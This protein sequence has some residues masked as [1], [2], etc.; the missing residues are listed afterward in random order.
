MDPVWKTLRGT[1]CRRRPSRDGIALRPLLLGLLLVG[2]VLSVWWFRQ[3]GRTV[4]RETPLMAEVVRGPYEHVVLEQGEVESSNNVEVRCEVKNQS[5]GNSPATTI[6]DVIPEGTTVEKGDWLITFD[7]RA[8]ENER[9]QQTI[10]VKTSQTLVIEAKAAYDT[11]VMSLRE[12]L[13]GTYLQERK[14]YE[15]EIFV[16]EEDL[17][18]AELTFDSIKRSVTRGLVSPLQL[19]GEQFRVDAARKVLELT[20]QKLQVLDDFTKEKMLTQFNSDI[21]ATKIKWENEQASY[22]E[23]LNRL[24]EIEEQIALC[25]VTAPQSGQVVYANVMSSRSGSEFVVEAGA[26]VRERQEIIRLPDPKNMQVVSNI[27]ESRINL[28]KEGM[29][30]TVKLDALGD[31][32]FSG[33]VTKV[34]KYA[35]A[36]NWWSSTAK[37]Y[38]TTIKIDNPPPQ[39]R[40]GLTAEVRIHVEESDDVLQVP[41]QAIL[42]HEGRTFCLVKQDDSY[43]TCPVVIE[44]SNDKMVALEDSSGSPLQANAQVVLNPRQYRDWMDLP[45]AVAPTAVAA[46]PRRT[47]SN[48]QKRRLH[49][50]WR[51]HRKQALW[52]SRCRTSSEPGRPS[53]RRKREVE[54]DCSGCALCNSA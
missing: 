26:A 6:L 48:R 3:G 44:S 2:V 28:I 4:S 25:T 47:R 45:A 42:E 29:R 10:A 40:S 30:A 24:Q 8:L 52:L 39:I 50:R 16:A 36:G 11:A 46:R 1:S 12:Y 49:R 35:E 33:S 13:E 27:N 17:K 38:G 20:R 15:N 31:E 21:E 32:L 41:V 14:T 5:G 9:M 7:S 51:P 18:K 23:E 19:Q 22:Q 53:L 34:N 37:E 54:A 43:V